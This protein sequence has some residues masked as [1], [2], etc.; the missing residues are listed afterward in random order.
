MPRRWNHLCWVLLTILIAAC[1]PSV[2]PTPEI[3]TVMPTAAQ[4]AA[5]SPTPPIVPR[6]RAADP[7]Q[8]VSLRFTHS[9]EGLGSIDV[10]A[11]MLRLTG[12]L[13]YGQSAGDALIVAGEY[14]F[15]LLPASSE[16][17]A[18]PWG[19]ALLTLDGGAHYTLLLSGS[20]ET[21][22]FTLL[23]DDTTP[24]EA[25]RS[26]IAVIA[27]DPQAAPATI[28]LASGGTVAAD[29]AYGQQSDA[30]VIPVGSDTLRVSVGDQV[31]DE[32]EIDF[33]EARLY[34][35]LVTGSAEANGTSQVS[36]YETEV[37]GLAY[38]RIVQAVDPELGPMDFYLGDVR[39]AAEQV[40]GTTSDLISIPNELVNLFVVPTGSTPTDTPLLSYSLTPATGDIITVM[41]AGTGQNNRV[42]VHSEQR[43]LLDAGQASIAFVNLDPNNPVLTA[44]GD[45][46]ALPLPLEVRYA[47]SPLPFTISAGE[48]LI[49]WQQAVNENNAAD[50]LFQDMLNLEA[51]T[52][53]LYVITGRTDSPAL[54]FTSQVGERQPQPQQVLN[55][56]VRWVNVVP[57]A[58]ITFALDDAIVA[59]SLNPGEASP[60]QPT[61][62]GN[63]TLRIGSGLANAEAFISLEPFRRYSIYA[64]G[65][66][67]SLRI[68]VIEDS[69]VIFSSG[70]A[71]IRLVQLGQPTDN[72][73]DLGLA[74]HA[75]S[76]ANPSFAVTPVAVGSLPISVPFGVRRVITAL[77]NASSLAAQLSAGQ[78]DF[79]MIDAATDGVIAFIPAAALAE[80]QAYEIVA[81]HLPGEEGVNIF[82]L[83][84]PPTSD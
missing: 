13:N 63:Y 50:T 76:A 53:Y 9:V 6:T 1:A 27:A 20:A 32:T 71:R 2:T 23:R 49:I 51:G 81:A 25:G 58:R 45:A 7:A 26:R 38:L 10:Y 44:V 68:A 41:A 33:A 70:T 62:A 35:I 28:A 29:L 40:F 75:G 30:A 80:R 36:Y 5:P 82:A 60:L 57:D 46:G 59:Q 39:I 64:F 79:Y 19:Q 83:S 55:S 48:Q 61:A 4:P 52:R 11:E 72:N 67:D 31:I 21:P 73:L 43:I 34:T 8:Q 54:L 12:A 66:P 16:A 74:P 14:L 47:S 84:Y 77:P 42:V 22:Q 3:P 18:A 24:L 69:D 56:H 78:Y 65:K 15:R 37:P 17:T